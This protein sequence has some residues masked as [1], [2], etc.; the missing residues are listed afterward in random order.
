M[1]H[2]LHAPQSQYNSTHISVQLYP[3]RSTSQ[4]KSQYISTQ[5][6]AISSVSLKLHPT[7]LHLSTTLPKS[8]LSGS[9]NHSLHVLLRSRHR[10][11]A[12][13]ESV[14]FFVVVTTV[15][16]R[17]KNTG[18]YIGC[19]LTKGRRF[20]AVRTTELSQRRLG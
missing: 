1:K 9:K 5:I 15:R 19:E 4:P 18:G 6:S 17:E 2:S 11:P 20:S 12:G 10:G 14:C 13:P 7:L 16:I 8:A 3:I